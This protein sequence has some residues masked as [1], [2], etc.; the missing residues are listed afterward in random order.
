[1]PID[2]NCQERVDLFVSCASLPQMQ[3]FSATDAFC[4]IYITDPL[5]RTLRKLSTTELIKNTI[6]PVYPTAYAMDYMFEIVQEIVVRVYQHNGSTSSNDETKHTYIGKGSFFLSNL[7]CA[8]NQKLECQICEGK[9]TGKVIIRGESQ[10]NTRDLLC[11][12][13]AGTKLANK[14]GFFGKSDPYLTISRINEDGSWT[15]VWK[16]N[17]IDNSLNPKWQP[18]K[19]PMSTL[20]NGDLDR[21]LNI[22]VM[23]WDKNGKHDS[24]GTLQTSV[25]ALLTGNGAGIDVIEE[26]VKAKKKSYVNSGQLFASNVLIEHHPT[27]A[28]FIAGG[29]Q[30]NLCVAIDFTASNGDPLSPSSLHHINPHGA[31]NAYQSAISAVGSVLE[32]YDTDKSYP[33]YGFGAKLKQA[34]G[35][36]SPVQHCFPVYGGGVEVQGVTG[37]LQAYSDCLNN[38]ALSGPT[39]FSPLIQSAIGIAGAGSNHGSQLKYTVLLIVTDGVINDMDATI[40]SIIQASGQPL[41]IIIVGVG[42][43]DFSGMA[44]LDSDG[45]VLSGGGRSAERD[46]VQFVSFNEFASKGPQVLASQVLAEV[47]TQCL[48]YYA[49]HN[50]LPSPPHKG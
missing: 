16:N 4:V 49:K 20:C 38:V 36:F 8:N 13:F 46:I 27:F 23:D 14:D 37:I 10:T 26:A 40:Q 7:M 50:I 2:T 22:E 15:Q 21:P 5:T 6:N 39:L 33:V 32:P 3:S 30:V 31:Y 29:L 24:M 41:S 1:M 42:N 9:N 47:P 35:T 48:S 45:K 43:A 28:E 25:R 17:V 11:V 44:A 34:D 12:T 19:I 18:T